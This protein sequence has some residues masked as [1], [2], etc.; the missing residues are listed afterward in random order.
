MVHFGCRERVQGARRRHALLRRLHHLPERS[1]GIGHL[2]LF[3]GRCSHGFLGQIQ[4]ASLI[5]FGLASSVVV[6]SARAPP[7]TVRQRHANPSRYVGITVFELIFYALLRPQWSF[8]CD[9]RRR[10]ETEIRMLR[11]V[12]QPA[13][14]KR[15]PECLY[16]FL[17]RLLVIIDRLVREV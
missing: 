12:Q 7:R 6:Q 13:E 8:P 4:R 16:R 15:R 3:N 5:Q 14:R 10:A 1:D 9:A 11:V 17:F 2:R